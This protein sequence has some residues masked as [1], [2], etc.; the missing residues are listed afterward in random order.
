MKLK[1]SPDDFHVEELTAMTAGNEGPFAY[2]RLEKR[3]WTTPDAIEMV[4]RRW[5][6]ELRQFSFGGLK[7]RYAHT[8]QYLTIFDGPKRDFTHP[9]FNVHY[10]GQVAHEYT[11]HD[12]LANRFTIALRDLSATDVDRAGEHS[13]KS[14]R[15]ACRTTSTINDL[16]RLVMVN[17]LLRRKWCSATSSQR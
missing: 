10:L 9:D 16:V 8:L 7:D 13:R 11:S 2:Y 12:I 6:T 15:S 17:R 1:Q 5:K 3:N 4:R 14:Q